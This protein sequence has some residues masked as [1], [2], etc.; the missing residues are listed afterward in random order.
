MLTKLTSKNQI[1]LPK[2]V[3]AHFADAEYFDVSE[4][5][6]KIILSPI[7][8]RD[9]DAIRSK[10]ATMGINPQDMQEAIAWARS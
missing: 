1:T 2:R 9:T 8:I 5:G 6:G 3:M 10:L 7:K 4:E